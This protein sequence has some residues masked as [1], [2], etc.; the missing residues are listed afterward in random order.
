MMEQLQIRAERFRKQGR[1]QE[2][3][4]EQIIKEM[5]AEG[6][7]KESE[8]GDRETAAD[9]EHKRVMEAV[10]EGL[11]Q[12]HGITPNTKQPGIFQLMGEN[13][14]GFNNRIGGNSKISKALD[15]K[16]E[17]DFNCL[18]YCKHR[19]NFQHKDNK[20]D[21]KQMFQR[22][23]ACTAIAA[24][25]VHEGMQAGRIQEGGTG[26]I[27]FKDATGYVKK[28]GCDDEGLGC[29]SWILLGGA[30]GHNTQ[31]IS[32]HNL[33]KNKIVNSGTSYQ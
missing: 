33:C 11:L 10:G 23:L 21:L 19:I 26:N 6:Q 1:L 29:W 32:A 15:I 8:R 13:C 18:M 2:D 30:E 20:N 28:V 25:N 9:N 17:L 3:D 14:N 27:C 7:I 5:K 22:E 16:E 31:I 24:H 12:V 4:L